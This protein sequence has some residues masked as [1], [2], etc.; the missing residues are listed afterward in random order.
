VILET[1]RLNLRSFEDRDIVPFAE[2]R[3]DPQVAKYQGWEAPFSLAQASEFVEEMKNRTPG[4]PGMWLQLAIEHKS[5]S[6][7]LGDV[8]FKRLFNDPRQAEIGFTLARE[9]QGKGYALEA[10]TRLIDYLFKELDLHR[11]QANCDPDNL[12]S[13]RLMQR[14]GMRHEGRFIESLWFK[15]CW[16]SEDWYAI[17]QREWHNNLPSAQSKR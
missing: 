14:A 3:S 17:L 16:A 2:Y 5:T 13:A 12:A 15:G 7:M 10:V 9:S 11:V 6:E 8:A 1:P 4:E